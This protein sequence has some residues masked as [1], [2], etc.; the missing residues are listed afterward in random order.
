MGTGNVA[1]ESD[2]A[3][4]MVLLKLKPSGT[5]IEGEQSYF[6]R[7]ELTHTDFIHAIRQS[8]IPISDEQAYSHG[9]RLDTAMLWKHLFWEKKKQIDQQDNFILA[10]QTRLYNVQPDSQ[11][12]RKARKRKDRGDDNVPK[13]NANSKR[14]KLGIPSDIEITTEN[15]AG[16]RGKDHCPRRIVSTD[17][18]QTTFKY[19]ES[20]IGSHKSCALAKMLAT[21]R[22]AYFICY[23]ML[24]Q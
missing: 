17:N 21:T 13:E 14:P 2:F 10:L 20:S 5:D 3:L 6:A 15:L 23:D 1:H 24:V 19:S 7:R 4:A 16:E 8:L 11:N 22:K 18:K 9:V 12:T